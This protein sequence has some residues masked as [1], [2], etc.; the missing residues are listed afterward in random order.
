MELTTESRS[1]YLIRALENKSHIFVNSC[2]RMNGLDPP[3]PICSLRKDISDVSVFVLFYCNFISSLIQN[4]LTI[5]LDFLSTSFLFLKK[6]LDQSSFTAFRD[7]LPS[8]NYSAEWSSWVWPP[9]A[10][11]NGLTFLKTW[12][13]PN[14]HFSQQRSATP[15]PASSNAK[16]RT[17]R[18]LLSAAGCHT[19][20]DGQY[21]PLRT[22]HRVFFN[23]RASLWGYNTAFIWDEYKRVQ[24]PRI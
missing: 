12:R 21:C 2:R 6:S 18:T 5:F 16:K 17:K 8:E 22:Y 7:L 13:A 23:G 10:D 11:S 1:K 20:L 9:A 14:G 19:R 3:P 15:D 24:T 4:G